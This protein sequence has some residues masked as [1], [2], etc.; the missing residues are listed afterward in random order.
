[1]ERVR[2]ANVLLLETNHDLKLL[3][4]DPHRP[5]S[6]KQRILSRHG[7]LCNDAAAD[8]AEQLV[9]D[10]LRLLYLAHLS[11]DCNRPELALQAVGGRLCKIGAGHIQIQ[12]TFQDVPCPTLTFGETA[13]RPETVPQAPARPTALKLEETSAEE[14][15][16]LLRGRL[17]PAPG[18]AIPQTRD[19][20]G[21]RC[22]QLR[23]F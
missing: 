23:L 19:W 8:L 10:E 21:R 13:L 9:S 2:A 18:L 3:Q 4:D 20:P 6:V 7:H 1:M 14:P 17:E 5:W 16:P 22:D 11:R 15:S 12:A